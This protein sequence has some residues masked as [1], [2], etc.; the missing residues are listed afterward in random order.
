MSE[1][2]NDGKETKRIGRRTDAIKE[3]AKRSWKVFALLILLF[4][5]LYY[6][7]GMITI[8]NIE[9]DT[10]FV[11]TGKNVVAGGSHAV[12]MMAGLIDRE[13]NV[14]R[15]TAN[16]PFF[17]PSA[18]LDNMPNY[19]QGIISALARFGFELT[20]QIGRTR[21]SSQTDPDLQE[22]AGLL[23]YSGT[24]WAWDPTI[25]L[26]PTAASE[27]QYEKAR[28]SLID[29][30]KRL[31]EGNAVFE[32]RADNLLATLDRI[33]LDMGSSTATI[34]QHVDENS[35]GFIDFQA[36]NIFYGVKG[37]SYG[38]YMLLKALSQDF[39]SLIKERGLTNA[40]AQMLDSFK[41]VI[42][43][44]PFIIVNAAPDSQFLPNHLTAQGFYVLRARTQLQEI[45]NILLK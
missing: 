42:D 14:N 8:N 10:S 15:W 7:I 4:L 32:R 23:Q 27:E 37:Q 43:L 2:G 20:D 13:I 11:P 25:S 16:D 6:P 5:I 41:Y 24:K 28:N 21:G 9:D 26:L 29:Y 40:W 18:A 12:D 45:S 30:N 44:D 34:D 36:D 33:A 35:G 19:Q 22:A 1:I 38:Y 31:A 17:M 39:E 3:G